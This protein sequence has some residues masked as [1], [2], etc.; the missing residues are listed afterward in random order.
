MSLPKPCLI[1]IAVRNEGA[2]LQ[3]FLPRLFEAVGPF[4]DVLIVSDN[5]TDD[6]VEAA[7][8]AGAIT[9]AQPKHRGKLACVRD[10]L[11]MGMATPTY[12]QFVTMDGDGQ[13]EPTEVARVIASLERHDVVFTSRYRGDC[14]KGMGRPP[15]DRRLLNRAC[16]AMVED[17]TGWSLTDPLCGLRGFR[18]EMV[19]WIL[20]QNYTSPDGYGFEIETVVRLWHR[21]VHQ[22]KPVIFTEIPHP[23]IYDGGGKISTLYTDEHLEGRLERI[24]MHHRHLVFAL[25]DLGI[26]DLG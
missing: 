5:S 16:R 24:K 18:R 19:E 3:T 20:S 23:A 25:R 11:H 6:T 13:H 8:H 1:V 14:P 17:I 7:Q 4:A 22:Q 21:H 9:I 26:E 15:I 12:T 2:A 10:G